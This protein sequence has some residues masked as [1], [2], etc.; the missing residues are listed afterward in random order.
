MIMQGQGNQI[1]PVVVEISQVVTG[2]LPNDIDRMV[3]SPQ[4]SFVA[5]TGED[6]TFLYIYRFY[7][8]GA[9]D[10]MQAWA[11]WELP[12]SIQDLQIVNDL[13]FMTLLQGD[14]Y[15]LSMVSLNT[16]NKS[17][18]QLSADLKK[19]GAPFLDSMAR[20]TSVVYDEL[21]NETKFYA[22]F[23]FIDNKKPRM[24]LTLPLYGNS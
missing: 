24:M 14:S 4:N 2:W 11:R 15:V 9:E 7:N 20:P 18:M 13:M 5:L 1:D 10:Q 6:S 22:P 16:L 3:V 17:G 19:P 21:N 23:P 8:D 12:G